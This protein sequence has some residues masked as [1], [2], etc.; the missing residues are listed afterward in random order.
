MNLFQYKPSFKN[1]VPLLLIACL[2]FS[3]CTK[4]EKGFL[5]PYFQYP[6]SLYSIPKGRLF[7]SDAINPDGSSVP[8]KVKLAHIYDAS[9]N[10]ADTMFSKT[11]PVTIWTSSYNTATDTTFDLINA[12][13]STAQLTPLQISETN[14]EIVANSATRFLPSGLYS[15]DLTITNVAGTQVLKKIVSFQLNDAPPFETAP[16]IG[17]VYDRLFMVGNESVVKSAKNPVFSIVRVADSPSVVIFKLLDKNGTPFNP[18]NGEI[19][20]RPNSGLNPNPPFLQN[21]QDYTHSYIATDTAMVFPFAF[22]PMPYVSLGNGYNLYYRIPTQFVHIDGFPDNTYSCNP[23]IPVRIWLPGTY[24][25]T[26]QFPDV[27]HR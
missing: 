5:S 25:I 23:R 14:G 24:N 26:M 9:G 6:Q 2:A 4:Y 17:S 1:G 10:I 22:T 20:K 12:K 7:H 19:V 18:K 11:Y 13:R 27:T 15:M 21:F 3:G 8:F 16:A